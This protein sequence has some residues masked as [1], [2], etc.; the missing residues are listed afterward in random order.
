MPANSI[1][2]RSRHPFD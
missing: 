2:F 1:E